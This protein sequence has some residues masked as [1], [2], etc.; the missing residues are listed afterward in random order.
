MLQNRTYVLLRE[1]GVIHCNCYV[2]ESWHWEENQKCE[3]ICKTQI[4][5]SSGK[6]LECF[7]FI[8]SI[9]SI[10]ENERGRKGG[11]NSKKHLTLIRFQRSSNLQI[12]I[13]SVTKKG[14]RTYR[15]FLN[16]FSF[17]NFLRTEFSKSNANSFFIS[18]RLF[19]KV[20]SLKK[21]Y[22]PCLSVHLKWKSRIKVEPKHT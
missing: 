20:G 13:S 3:R 9:S 21:W 18:L 11:T 19:W 14:A 6:K 1:K 22:I 15:I 17:S 5:G 4:K 10:K 16:S 8:L 2:T 7:S 12:R